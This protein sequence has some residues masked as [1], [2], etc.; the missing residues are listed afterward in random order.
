MKVR[1][2]EYR[3]VII[4]EQEAWNKDDKDKNRNDTVHEMKG[5]PPPK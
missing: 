1:C 2:A 5:P 3:Y 4:R